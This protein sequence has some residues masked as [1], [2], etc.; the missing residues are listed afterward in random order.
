MPSARIRSWSDDIEPRR[1][2]HT[3]AIDF[4]KAGGRLEDLQGLLGHKLLETTRRH[5]APAL[6]ALLQ[7]QVNRRKLR[8]A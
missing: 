6:L 2:R 5:Y 4:L 7:K 3:F 1:L 8:L